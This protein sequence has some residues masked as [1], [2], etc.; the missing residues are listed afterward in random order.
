MKILFI[1]TVEFS[2][3]ALEKLIELDENIVGVVTK[4]KSEFNSDFADLSAIC[5]KNSIPFIFSDNI[6]D[7]ETE[8]WIREREPDIGFCFGWSQIIKEKIL[9]I[10]PMGIIGFHPAKLPQNRGRHPI[11]WALFLG[12]QNTASTFF[13]MDKGADSGLVISQEDVSISYYDTA[14]TLY[15]KIISVA[16]KQMDNFIP[17]LKENTITPIKQDDTKS[18]VWRKRGINDGLIDFRMCSFAIYNLVRALTHPYV[19][20]H[21]TYKGQEIKVWKVEELQFEKSNIEP[22]FVIDVLEN[23][24][25]IVKTYDNAIKIIEHEFI[26]LPSK[27]EYL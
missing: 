8:K 18:N 15:E 17:K 27:G 10:P 12:L 4:A 24:S 22:G 26:E 1:G 13:K 5:K 9:N 7:S 23:C 2:L 14:H 3:K 11:I 6:N 20:A 21:I 19:G 25:V 16:L